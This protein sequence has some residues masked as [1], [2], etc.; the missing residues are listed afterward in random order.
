MK[1]DQDRV[2]RLRVDPEVCIASGECARAVPEVFGQRVTD[3]SV[4]L[5]EES[6]PTALQDRVRAAVIDCPSGAIV[7]SRA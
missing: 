5:H 6:L 2:L 3:G 7:I 1:A 4:T